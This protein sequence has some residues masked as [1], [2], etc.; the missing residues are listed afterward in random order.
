MLQVVASIENANAGTSYSVPRLNAELNA[1]GA[2]SVL[3]SVATDPRTRADL[4]DHAVVHPPSLSRTPVLRRLHASISLQQALVSQAGA[5]DVLH[6]HGLWLLPNVYPA[7]AARNLGKP[8]VFSPR[9]MLGAAALRFS[10]LKK[11]L[12]WILLQRRAA[13]TAACIH[14]T[15]ES[16]YEDVRAFGLEAPVA[17]VGNGVD[18]PEPAKKDAA[19]GPRTILSLGRIHPKKGLDRLI[20]AWATVA[21][22]RPEWRLRLVGPDE[23][24]H[25]GVLAALAAHLAVDRVSI[26][27][28]L[29]GDAKLAAYRKADL[30]VLPSLHENFGMTV[31]EALAAGTPVISSKGAPWSGLETHRCGWWV[32][33]GAEPLAAAL[34]EATLAPPAF[35][36]EK[37]LRGRAWMIRDFSW[38]AKAAEMIAVYAWLAG[39]SDEP[40]H[41]RRG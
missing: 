27:G 5:A 32:D 3:H 26:E 24:G 23:N 8:F 33:Q 9:G 17:I 15:A 7:D 36:N 25:A 30:F 10:P 21:P 38:A 28:P 4:S 41:V 39:R 29:H 14:A 31:A 35:L 18:I 34:A 11:R 2:R 16:E 22:S 12:F 20:T 13:Q 6:A 1:Q 37:G 40:H 19:A